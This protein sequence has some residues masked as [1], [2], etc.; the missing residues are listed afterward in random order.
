MCSNKTDDDQQHYI[1]LSARLQA[2][3]IPAQ[4]PRH[5]VHDRRINERGREMHS[6]KREVV[7][8]EMRRG[9]GRYE[10]RQAV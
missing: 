10:R 6:R 2:M 4:V 5:H 1:P 8:S 7:E 3:A 9:R